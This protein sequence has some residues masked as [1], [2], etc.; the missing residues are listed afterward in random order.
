LRGEVLNIRRCFDLGGDRG[1]SLFY[2]ARCWDQHTVGVRKRT[3]GHREEC[4]RPFRSCIMYREVKKIMSRTG[5]QSPCT[6]KK[7]ESERGERRE[8]KR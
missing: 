7:K 6:E 1:R 2:S 3:Y 4:P 5:H 8:K